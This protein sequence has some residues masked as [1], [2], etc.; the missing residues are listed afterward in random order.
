MKRCIEVTVVAPLLVVIAAFAICGVHGIAQAEP[1]QQFAFQVTG[2]D[3]DDLA[4]RL[5]LRRFDT[6]GVVPPTPTTFELRL[7]AG[8]SLNPA[9][10]TT[11]YQCDGVALRDALD[12]H[13][14][15]TP[16][17][18]RVAHLDVFAR[19]LERSHAKRD[20][21][22]LANV[23]TCERAQLG[24]G[25]GLVDA[26]DA[27]KVLTDPI[28][29]RFSVFLSAGTAPGAVAGLAA[30][31][32]ADP[33]SAI[34]RRYP[35]V[36]G[37]HAVEQENFFSDP[38][39]DGLYDLKLAIYTGPINGFQVSRARV[40]ATVRSL[41]IRRGTCLARGHGGRCVRHQRADASLFSL[42]RC[43]ASK[44]Y[45]VQLLAAYPPP[46]PSVTTTTEVACPRFAP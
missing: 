29:F 43:S 28:P 38:S 18:V 27:I 40:D 32:A 6:T 33:R 10:L 30:L 11:R 13:L 44:R 14:S 45:S 5:H 31:G 7:P 3:P 16:F 2:P 12:A 8:V 41:T 36:A 26:R 35:V 42:P 4:V 23:R 25:S 21:A 37:V 17:D 24:G 22:A 34:V 19:E 9:F 1:V 46:T 15:G 20:R 39:P